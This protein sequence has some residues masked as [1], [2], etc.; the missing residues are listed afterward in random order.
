LHVAVKDTGLGIPKEAQERIFKPFGQADSS[1]TRLHGGTGLGLAISRDICTAMGGTL[2]VTS[3]VGQGSSF[4]MRLPLPIAEMLEDLDQA[5]CDEP[6]PMRDMTSNG[7]RVLI[8]DDSAT[9]RLVLRKLLKSQDLVLEEA[10]NGMI[11]LDL[12]KTFH[13][14]LVLMDIQMPYLDGVETTRRLRSYYFEQEQMPPCVAAVTANVMPE[15][16]QSY[17][18]AGMDAVL[19]KPIER[20]KLYDILE[21]TDARKQRHRK[22]AS[23]EPVP[24][25]KR[26]G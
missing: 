5:Q 22:K 12:I 4:D 19:S 25:Q 9:N 26:A 13:P 8:V 17:L 1:I 14:D 10:Q 20:T 11:A 24:D 7:L 2:T 16:I 6:V 15:Q 23:T 3:D 21:K 18:S